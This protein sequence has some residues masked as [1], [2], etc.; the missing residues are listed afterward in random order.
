MHSLAPGDKEASLTCITRM[1]FADVFIKR[2][3]TLCGCEMCAWHHHVNTDIDDILYKSSSVCML[4]VFLHLD[5]TCFCQNGSCVVWISNTFHLLTWRGTIWSYSIVALLLGSA[6][7]FRMNYS[8]VLGSEESFR[9]KI[10]REI[11]LRQEV[12]TGSS[13]EKHCSD[14]SPRAHKNRQLE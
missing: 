1:A 10:G 11:M 4:Y 3:T 8:I 12:R 7:S 13:S 6:E 2:W 9:M 14:Y 5:K